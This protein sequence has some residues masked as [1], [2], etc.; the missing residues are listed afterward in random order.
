MSIRESNGVKS[1]RQCLKCGKEMF[2]DRCHRI[3]PKCA[4]EN[5]RYARGQITLPQDVRH[6]MR[7]LCTLE[8]GWIE[9][10]WPGPSAYT[11]D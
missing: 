6:V 7:D 1:R 3:C 2:T 10:S 9:R 5:E 4:H 11:K 8:A